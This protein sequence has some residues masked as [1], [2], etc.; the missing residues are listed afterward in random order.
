MQESQTTTQNTLHIYT[1]SE[2][3]DQ[4]NELFRYQQVSIEGEL[5]EI[6]ISKN[7]WVFFQLKDEHTES[8][9]R[10]FAV[11]SRIGNIPLQ[12]G[13]KVEITGYAKLHEKYGFSIV[14]ERIIPKGEGALKKAFE[15]LKNKLTKEGI[16]AEEHKRPIPQIPQQIAL[17]ASK[18]SAAYSD[19]LKILD[20]RRGGISIHVLNTAVQGRDA[21]PSI[22]QALQHVSNNAQH[23][24]T[25]VLTRGGGSIEDLQSFNTEE[26][27]RAVFRCRVPIVC[28]VGHE[29]DET[30]AEYAADLRASTPSNAAEMISIENTSLLATL[31][32][33][34]HAREERLTQEITKKK[35]GIVHTVSAFS[36]FL[37][38]Q[39]HRLL[40]A[41][42]IL[43]SAEKQ[44]FNNARQ[45]TQQRKHAVFQIQKMVQYTLQ[46]SNDEV[47]DATQF[48]SAVNPLG[49]L[50]KGYSIMKNSK[51]GKIITSIKAVQK[52][53]QLTHQLH[54]GSIQTNV[55]SMEKSPSRNNNHNNRN[56]Q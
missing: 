46:K 31:Q 27:V 50:Q 32:N 36:Q 52:N 24:D 44:I 17:I 37:T 10:C 35:Q 49:L 25:A 2:Y 6:R 47:Q 7:L 1:V 34:I 48:L 40:S 5:Q 9:L 19:F 39:Q 11:K 13:M 55:T 18:E 15:E 38:N 30:L 43:R 51:T 26:V 42:A 16:F 33:A 41:Q 45:L 54:D 29:R 53:D 28:A 21:I 12:D 8:V 3:I 14:T 23:Y 22:V 4:F 56:T 20:T